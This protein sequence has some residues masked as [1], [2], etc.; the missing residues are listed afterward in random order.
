MYYRPNRDEP[1]CYNILK[2]KIKEL[3]I[4]NIIMTGDWNIVLASRDYNDYTHVNNTK[5]KEAV[6]GMLKNKTKN[7]KT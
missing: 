3:D 4:S 7:N 6:L 2:T 5:A 1:E